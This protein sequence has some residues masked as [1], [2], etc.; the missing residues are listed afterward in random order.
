MFANRSLSFKL[1]LV[2][3][4][5]F[6]VL[7]LCFLVISLISLS[8]TRD[9]IVGQVSEEIRQQIEN[10]MSSRAESYAADMSLLIEKNYAYSHILGQQ[11][12]GSI[13][14][15]AS[16]ALNR[17]QVEHSVETLLRGG[18]TSSMYAQFEKNKFDGNASQFMS[19]NSHSVPGVGSFE[20]YF[21]REEDGSISQIPIDDA[22]EKF[23]ETLDEFG[24]RAAEWYLCNKDRLKPCIANP[25]NYEIRPGY[26]EVMTSLTVPV[27]ANDSFR[28][29]VGVD[30]N[31]PILQQY[32]SEL[33]ASL[34]NGSAEVYVISHD[35][36]VAAATDAENKLA[37]P[38]SEIFATTAQA[39]LLDNI[40]T[41]SETQVHDGFMYLA[42]PIRLSTPDVN[43]QLIVAVN[44]DT[45]MA[46]AT[47]ISDQIAGDIS[48]LLWMLLIA[49]GVLLAVALI[50]VRVFTGSVVDP[51][52][53]V[54][55][56]MSELAGQ[57]GDL[58]QRIDVRSHAEL[59]Q[60][61]TAF[62]QFRETVREIMEEAKEAGNS[63]RQDSEESAG[64]AERTSEQLQRQ[65][66]E[67]D[68]VVSAITQMSETAREVASTASDSSRYANDANESVKQTEGKVSTSADEAKQLAEQMR[69]AS[70]AV[71]KVS[72]RSDEIRKILDVIGAVAE[73]TNLLALNAA[74]EA[75]RAGDHGRGFSVVADEVRALASKTAQSVDETSRVIDGLQTE[76]ATTV[77]IIDK[78]N[79]SANV[80][81]ERSHEAFAQ[82]R[83]TVQNIDEISQRM[84]QL[85]TAAEE[86]SQVSDVLNQ[87]MVVIG[88]AT[89]NVSELADS[90]KVSAQNIKRAVEKLNTYLDKLKTR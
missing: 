23:D 55:E 50:L 78:G 60:L 11:L 22:Q 13:E 44:Y 73:Q 27:I 49:G 87:N 5:L 51:V 61:S 47:R 59:I 46:P 32:A 36:F 52:R 31:L 25:Y 77:S 39:S 1:Q 85:A 28:G 29:V 53:L 82:M 20:I 81:A 8:Q 88:D 84:I 56:K 43:W 9:D 7:T 41:S 21:V 45:A 65:L 4:L 3:G 83:E 54:A 14:G 33:K 35:R 6:I 57:G 66:S 70:E 58:T 2:V 17:A 15:P 40:V 62:N 71:S 42:R 37:R 72:S 64:Y 67:I 19:G 90:S 26:T 63:V 68:S 24:N 48:A 80:A 16:L 34:Y 79:E 89:K 10:T 76:V 38:V 86:Q 12:A 18:S 69:T 74:I 30:L 75:A